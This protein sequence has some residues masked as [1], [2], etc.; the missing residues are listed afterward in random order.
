LN[1]LNRKGII[2]FYLCNYSRGENTVKIILENE[3][4]VLSGKNKG[5]ANEPSFIYEFIQSFF[6]LKD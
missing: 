3:N 4:G 5:S 2:T 1:R 6:S